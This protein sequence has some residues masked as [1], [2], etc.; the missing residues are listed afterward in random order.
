VDIKLIIDIL[1]VLVI[2]G[3]IGFFKYLMNK[4]EN[5]EQEMKSKISEEDARQLLADHLEP[6]KEDL[7]DIKD[8][9]IKLYEFLLK[10]K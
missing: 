5:L 9:Q 6:V 2:P 10:N 4:I 1:L 8:L 3:L 7:Q